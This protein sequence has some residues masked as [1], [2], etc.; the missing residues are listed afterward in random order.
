[1][2]CPDGGGQLRRTGENNVH[3]DC[4]FI[5]DD[6]QRGRFD[7]LNGLSR[8]VREMLIL[9]SRNRMSGLTARFDGA[10]RSP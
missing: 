3:R 10:R 7:R 9:P 5:P 8:Q 1:M 4:F 6:D 2:P